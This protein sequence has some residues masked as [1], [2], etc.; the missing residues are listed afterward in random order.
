MTRAVPSAAD[1]HAATI[2][3][4]KGLGSYHK[5]YRAA[6]R[7]RTSARMRLIARPVVFLSPANELPWLRATL[8][9]YAAL[10]SDGEVFEVG[11]A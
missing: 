1:L 4:L 3:V 9:N 6:F 11:A 5:P 2:E 10:V 8:E 7:Y